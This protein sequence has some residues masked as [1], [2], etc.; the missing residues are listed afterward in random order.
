MARD[1][2]LDEM[3]AERTKINPEFPR[4]L[5]EAVRRRHASANP[6]PDSDAVG[7]REDPK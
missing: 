6:P 4:L 5:D 3:I 1:D 2:L 7:D